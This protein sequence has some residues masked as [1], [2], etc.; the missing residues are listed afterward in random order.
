M[1]PRPRALAGARAHRH[2]ALLK[3]SRR[4]FGTLC[5][6]SALVSAC[7]G[8]VEE[9]RTVNA[10]WSNARW[11]D[12]G[13]SGAVLRAFD[14]ERLPRLELEPEPTADDPV[15]SARARWNG[16]AWQPLTLETV[17]GRRTT[18]VPAPADPPDASAEPPLRLEVQF[19]RKAGPPLRAVTDAVWSVPPE[20]RPALSNV[21]SARKAGDLDRA[22]TLLRAADAP[23]LWASVEAARVQQARGDW[24][25]TL[26]AWLESARAAERAGIDSEVA[27]RTMSAAYAA[28]WRHDTARVAALLDEIAPVVRAL[29][30]PELT[31]FEAYYRGLLARER[32]NY[33]EGAE[34]HRRALEVAVRHGVNAHLRTFRMGLALLEQYQGR[35]SAALQWLEP[36]LKRDGPSDPGFDVNVAW[37]ET[38]AA[39]S[40]G[41]TQGLDAARRRL[42]RALE[43]LV[44]SGARA[45]A[46][47]AW[48][49]LAWLEQVAGAPAAAERALGEAAR[50]DPVGLGASRAFADTLAGELRWAQG[51]ASGALV[52]LNAAVSR[53]EAEDAPERQWRALSARARALLTLDRTAAA[54]T[55]LRAARV[56]LNDT[57]RRT[58][59]TEVR[60][61]YLAERRGLLED[62]LRA[63]LGDPP[64]R[65]GAA[66]N[67]ALA[68]AFALV[69][70]S[71]SAVL[72]SL[73]VRGRVERLPAEV[74]ARWDAA[75]EVWLRARDAAERTVRD[76]ELGASTPAD[77][78]R[79][80]LDARRAYDAAWAV[81]D[82]F[83]GHAGAGALD[84]EA[85]RLALGRDA[86]LVS[87]TPWGD[88]ALAFLV[89]ADGLQAALCGP[90]SARGGLPPCWST[91]AR[92]LQGRRTLYV[93]DGGHEATRALAET[94]VGSAVAVVSLPWAGLLLRGTRGSPSSTAKVE[95]FADPDASLRFAALEGKRVAARLPGARLRTGA[96]VTPA[97]LR[98]ALE[99][100]DVVHFAGHGRLRPEDPFAAHLALAGGAEF[101][102]EGVLS[103]P[104]RS[105]LVVLSG[106][107]TAVDQS[108]A[109]TERVSLADAFLAAGATLVLATDAPLPDAEAAD[110]VDRFYA[111]G[112]ATAPA[113]TLYALRKKEDAE[114]FRWRLHGQIEVG[115]SLD[116]SKSPR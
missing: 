11:T 72:R 29:D 44:R 57:T 102:L 62:T 56:A 106:C 25:L 37:I 75:R 68:E 28:L 74:R 94:A 80:R 99:H 115:A 116:N 52:H 21:V 46:A 60:A 33:R 103:S 6:W 40:K 93:V 113:Q 5:L 90:W 63:L 87:M 24:A 73:D 1:S 39:R 67:A 16:G 78:E 77:V 89:D 27:R 9:P 84:V 95:V 45:R 10:R 109:A 92:R 66:S 50:M 22:D 20:Q 88:Q 105:R 42:E 59:V 91:W 65:G 69:D 79:A 36:E 70:A 61:E 104:V 64:G 15:V 12:L 96:E 38:A 58:A 8:P 98:E 83:D 81:V 3:R 111:L 48:T 35:F 31:A 47:N 55:D 13:P 76:L 17:D 114:A 54:L 107:E 53:A 7:T 43:A 110:W 4:P 18:V 71:Q 97:A 41:R 85:L 101:S 49:N 2:P 100:A 19:D 14:S 32:G 112:G 108:L 26:S 34:H 30:E 51:D 23:P 82:A 86:A